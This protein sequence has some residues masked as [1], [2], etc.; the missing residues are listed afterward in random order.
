MKS[1]PQLSSRL[2]PRLISKLDALIG[3]VT[4]L[5]LIIEKQSELL[6]RL[7]PNEKEPLPSQI[8]ASNQPDF[9][10]S[11]HS[12]SLRGRSPEQLE[13]LAFAPRATEP[14]V[15]KNQVIHPTL[16]SL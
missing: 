4:D 1:Q 15:Q 7:R 3:K 12:R 10:P 8:A 9:K 2:V 16:G 6:Q 14:Q 11:S 13:Q 5:H